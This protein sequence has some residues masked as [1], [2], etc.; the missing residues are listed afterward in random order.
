[1]YV[2]VGVAAGPFTDGGRLLYWPHDEG[3]CPYVDNLPLEDAVTL[4]LQGGAAVFNGKCAHAAEPSTNER[5]SVIGFTCVVGP[6]RPR[7]GSTHTHTHAQAP[8]AAEASFDEVQGISPSNISFTHG[9]VRSSPSMRR[10][11]RSTRSSMR[12]RQSSSDCNPFARLMCVHTQICASC[13][14]VFPLDQHKNFSDESWAEHILVCKV[15]AVLQSKATLCIK[16]KQFLSC[17]CFD[18]I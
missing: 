4:H 18:Q 6:E 5:C 11:Y 10:R 17:A 2:F 7:E 12:T 1:M 14:N 3:E 16:L 15:E 13:G 8:M 9:H